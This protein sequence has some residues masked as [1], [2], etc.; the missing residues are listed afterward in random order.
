MRTTTLLFLLM[1]LP[2]CTVAQQAPQPNQ[3]T[4]QDGVVQRGNHVM[5]FSHDLTTHHFRLL[6]D[7]GEIIV[8]ANDSTM[9]FSVSFRRGASSRTASG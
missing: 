2:A 1:T 4:R 5:R 9:E 6:K 3:G 8:L 7:G